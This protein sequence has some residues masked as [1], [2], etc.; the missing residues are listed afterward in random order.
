[1]N[2]GRVHAD[3]V[4]CRHTIRGLKNCWL[5]VENNSGSSL[6]TNFDGAKNLEKTILSKSSINFTNHTLMYKQ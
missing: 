2:W 5:G 6:C 1:M 3:L 4:L